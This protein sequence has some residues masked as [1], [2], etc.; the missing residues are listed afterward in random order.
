MIAVVRQFPF[1][2]AVLAL[3]LI[4]LTV[5]VWNAW[6]LG[7]GLMLLLLVQAVDLARAMGLEPANDPATPQNLKAR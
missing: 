5:V 1:R 6:L 4:S 2:S 3:S 7:A